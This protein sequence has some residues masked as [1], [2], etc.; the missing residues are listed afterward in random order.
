M[1]QIERPKTWAD[2]MS[3]VKEHGLDQDEHFSLSFGTE[4]EDK[5]W[6]LHVRWITIYLVEGGSEGF[7][8]HMDELIH[9]KHRQVNESTPRALGKFWSL[10]E[11]LKA[12]SLLTY[13]VYGWSIPSPQTVD[14]RVMVEEL[15]KFATVASA[16]ASALASDPY[17]RGYWSGKRNAY[18]EA[19]DLLH[20]GKPMPQPDLGEWQGG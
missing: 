7:Y 2:V 15:G 9:N 17:W 20:T 6:P 18:L 12:V 1:P 3:F 14:V 16:H 19:R 10:E 5:L 11:G 8:L 4:P 13:Y